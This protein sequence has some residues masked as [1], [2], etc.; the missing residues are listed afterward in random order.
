LTHLLTFLH[1]GFADGST[2]VRFGSNPQYICLRRVAIPNEIKIW[3]AAVGKFSKEHFFITKIAEVNLV[4]IF[5]L[6]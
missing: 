5:I 2:P 3:I 1:Y 4:N 6:L